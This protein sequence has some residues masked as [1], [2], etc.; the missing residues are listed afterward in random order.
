MTRLHTTYPSAP[1]YSESNA[2]F[3]LD[4]FT[5]GPSASQLDERNSREA[6]EPS[7][8]GILVVQGKYG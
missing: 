6:W 2:R 4:N 3:W 7:Q 5:P 1:P 8:F